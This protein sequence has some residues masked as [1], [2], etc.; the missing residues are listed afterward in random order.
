MGTVSAA[1]WVASCLLTCAKN[2]PEARGLAHRTL[3][4]A[5][6]PYVLRELRS[7]MGDTPI[8]RELDAVIAGIELNASLE[9][10]T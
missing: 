5:L 2:H 3:A 1:W 4:R 9:D 7:R 8:A 10:A 6:P